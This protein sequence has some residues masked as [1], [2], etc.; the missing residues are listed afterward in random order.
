MTTEQRLVDRLMNLRPEDNFIE[1]KP[2]AVN[3]REL[4]QT[5]VA[6]S[7]SVSEPDTAVLYIGV[8]DKTGAILGINDADSLQKRV[9]DAGEECYPPIQP[10]MTVLSVDG[11][12]V[13]AVEVAHSKEKPHFAGPAYIRSGSRSVKAS[14]SLYRDLLTSHCSK[15]GEIL[16]CKGKHVTVVTV[17]KRLGNQYG[18][19]EPGYNKT[20]MC[21]VV[22]CDPFN[23]TLQLHG[24]DERC[25]EPLR[26]IEID[27]DPHE[28][29]R[30]LIVRGEAL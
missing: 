21:T 6:F 22:D 2:E 29:R 12:Q 18:S 30:M 1:R 15:A 16:K 25:V 8:H 20:F 28:N 7:N 17:N 24:Y 10:L 13:L 23:V 14:A 3:A 26:R 19:F 11:K 4:R 27:L 9:G 5:L